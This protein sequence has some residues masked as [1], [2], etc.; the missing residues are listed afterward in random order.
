MK[1]IIAPTDF[2]KV[3][4]NACLYAANLAADIKADLVL[5]HAMEIPFAVTEYPVR[6][7]V[8]GEG[9]IENEL[10]SLKNKL[11][12]ETNNKVAVTIKK[13][14]GSPEYEITE[15]CKTTEPF[16]VVM[17]THTTGLFDRLFS[18]STT[19]YS[20]RNLRC[21][22]IIVPHDG[23]YQPI[24]RI[25]LASD[26]KDIYDVSAQEI[27]KIIR[28][29]DAEFEV[30]YA[31]KKEHAAGPD[32]VENLLLEYRSLGVNPQFHVVENEDVLMG[33]TDLAKERNVQM[34]II[35]PKKHGVFH[36]SHSKDFV[37]YA[38]VPVMTVHEDDFAAKS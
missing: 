14:L 2:S 7:V 25:A 11:I 28:L 5:L 26:L 21:P 35:I 33:I 4:E 3:S 30:F 29:F 24:K 31:A 6:E 32:S 12:I 27:T 13:I 16:A 1:T 22:V 9:D 15:L 19:L 20:A 8:F 17:G 34:L 10:E 18:R 37:F 38:D 36:K 23:Q